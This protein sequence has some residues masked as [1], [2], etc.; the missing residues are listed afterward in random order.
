M[1]VSVWSGAFPNKAA[2][3]RIRLA[4]KIVLDDLSILAIII[5]VFFV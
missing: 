5:V 1:K 3:P 2:R 4:T